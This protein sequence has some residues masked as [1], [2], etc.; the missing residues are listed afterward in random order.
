MI[1]KPT[2]PQLIDA[3]CVALESTVVPAV[4]GVAQDTL[5][6]AIGILKVL[7]VRAGHEIA[8]M[9][10]ESD[11][12]VALARRFVDDLPDTD[13][14]ASA[15]AE[16][17]SSSSDSLALDDVQASYELAGE[18]LSQAIEC[19]YRSGSVDHIVE[20][21]GTVERRIQHQDLTIGTFEAAG[22]T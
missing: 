19:A 15:L 6:K 1:S 14:L 4:D 5:E 9:R 21:T 8:W 3:V 17:A 13:A 16:L 18:V 12:I 20:A 11:E 2:T 7:S 10:E 22:R